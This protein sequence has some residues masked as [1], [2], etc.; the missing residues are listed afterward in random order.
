KDGFSRPLF[1]HTGTSLVYSVTLDTEDIMHVVVESANHQVT[2]YNLSPTHPVK[3][4]VLED[5]RF[6]Y[7]F[8]NLSIQWLENE[9]HLFYT[10]MHPNGLNRSL[11]HQTLTSTSPNLENLLTSLPLKT[12]L[13]YYTL[14]DTL[15]ILYPA[16]EESYCLNMLIFNTENRSITTLVQSS[17]PI[18]D[19]NIC[20]HHNK[21]YVLYKGDQ[22]G[23]ATFHLLDT[24]TN[25]DLILSIPEDANAPV[26][27]SYLDT[28]WIH[29][30]YNNRCYT[31]VALPEADTFSSPIVSHLQSH[32]NPYAYIDLRHEN[33]DASVL[34]ASLSST[35]RLLTIA[36][37]DIRGIH[38]DLVAQDE[39]ALLIEGIN[40]RYNI[41]STYTSASASIA[42]T[43]LT[44][45]TPQASLSPLDQLMNTLVQEPLAFTPEAPITPLSA[46]PPLSSVSTTLDQQSLPSSPSSALGAQRKDFK[47]LTEAFMNNG[48]TFET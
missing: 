3:R 13:S 25:K 34:Y 7:L 31:L 19:W 24:S 11:V 44:T 37:L 35:L 30:S 21:L 15:Y 48:N 41:P 8:E 33:M 40:F 32:V 45:S 18:V 5:S 4:V 22:Y 20:S 9:P 17:I 12:P 27:L 42:S 26:L 16:Y 2:Y 14:N 46:L 38:P 6:V 47:S 1:I 29:Y 43:P 36:D 23:H 28:L 10:V 39:L